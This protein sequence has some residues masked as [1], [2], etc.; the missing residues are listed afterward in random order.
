MRVIRLSA[1]CLLRHIGKF[2]LT[3]SKLQSLP[4]R[5]RVPSEAR[6]VGRTTSR[7][8]I[9]TRR[10]TRAALPSGE[11]WSKLH[12][13]ATVAGKARATKNNRLST[14]ATQSPTLTAVHMQS[15]NGRSCNDVSKRSQP[16]A[17]QRVEHDVFRTPVPSPD[18]VRSQAFR[19]HA[20]QGDADMRETF[21]NI[22][23]S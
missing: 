11:G 6:R 15:I 18:Q 22:V 14:I 23:I 10:A 8:L 21:A 12:T 13:R 1:R 3:A 2:P 17:A 4:R 7:A 5:G 20:Q 9:P 16:G 19:D